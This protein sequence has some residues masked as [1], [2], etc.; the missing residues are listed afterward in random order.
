MINANAN[1]MLP[2]CSLRQL[3]ALFNLTQLLFA[4]SQANVVNF[5]FRDLQFGKHPHL[6]KKSGFKYLNIDSNYFYGSI[7]M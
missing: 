4:L 5:T 6:F 3:E 7:Y 1:P 2:L